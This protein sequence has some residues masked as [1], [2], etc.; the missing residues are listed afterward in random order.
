MVLNDNKTVGVLYVVATPIGNLED[1][2]FRAIKVLQQ[3]DLIAAEDTRHTKK[4]LNYYEI[5][6]SLQ[7]CY[8]ENEFF[9]SDKI[10]DQLVQGKSVALVSDAGTPCISD[11]GSI[12]VNKAHEAEVP[13]SIIPGPSALISA[14]SMSGMQ[15]ENFQFVGF[16][17][18]KKSE[19]RKTLRSHKENPNVMIFYESPRRVV[20]CLQDIFDSWGDRTVFVVR[21]LTKIHE[22]YL[23]GTI[24]QVLHN[25]KQ[26]TSIKGEFVVI[27]DGCSQIEVPGSDDI[28]DM[29]KW[30]RDQGGNS[31]S[32]SVKKI[33]KD[34]G[35]PRA[36]VY[37]EAL[38]I[39]DS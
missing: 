35:I 4:L 7:S 14:L 33:A 17:P 26:R 12:L 22:E 30:Y 34:L 16:L 1:I 32:Y 10:I 25:L 6:T 31:L 24:S 29:I 9:R 5:S 2:T 18:N 37:K 3:V 36:K 20:G 38:K 23:R 21:E 15:Y 8:R 39:W 13:V 19:R 28:V 27:V 11:P